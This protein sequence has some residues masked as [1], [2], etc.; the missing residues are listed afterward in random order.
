MRAQTGPMA[1][2]MKRVYDD[3]AAGDGF[4][5]LVDRL[6]PR[7]V[8]KER[9][10]LDLW[11][12]DVAPSPQLRTAWHH[13][14][15]DFDRFAGDYRSELDRNPAATDRPPHA[16][17]RIVGHANRHAVSASSLEKLP[18]ASARLS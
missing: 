11:D 1:F 18:Q 9:A 10:E 17:R 13:H 2:T 12:K 15:E 16:S 4:R 14:L 7:G 5:V 8:S 3:A 6:W